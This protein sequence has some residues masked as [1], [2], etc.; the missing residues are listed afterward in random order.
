MAT[1]NPKTAIKAKMFTKV[2]TG[3]DQ[4]MLSSHSAI[5]RNSKIDG[6]TRAIP[7]SHDRGGIL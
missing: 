6:E 5:Y 2:L 7:K 4:S 1:P 3:S